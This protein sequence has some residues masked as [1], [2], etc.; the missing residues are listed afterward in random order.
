MSIND[1]RPILIMGATGY[2]GGRLIPRLLERGWRVRAAARNIAKLSGRPWT[3]HPRLEKVRAEMTDLNS[4]VQAALGCRAAYYLVHSMISAGKRY[5]EIDR[6]SALHMVAAVD[7]A[8][9][10]RLLYLGGLGEE[11]E[12]LSGHLRS[13]AEVGRILSSGRTPTTIL[14]A[15]MILGSGSASFEMLRYLAERLPI[16]VTP[17]WVHTQ[18]QP[19]AIRNVLDY[20]VGCL[21]N[22][23]TAGRRF[24]IGG[25]DIL[26]YAELFNIYASEAGLNRRWIVPT[27]FF[28]PKLSSYWIHMV[29]PV[30]ASIAR[31]LAEGL[32]NK[33]VVR[34][35]GIVNL[36]P[37]ELLTCREAMRSA[38]EKRRH[39]AMETCWLDSPAPPPEWPLCEDAEYTGGMTLKSSHRAVVQAAPG[40]AWLPIVRLGGQNGYYSSMFLW[41]LRGWLDRMVGGMGFGRKRRDPENLIEGDVFDFW[42]VVVVEPPRRLRLMAEVRSPGRAYLEFVL[43]PLPG[44]QTEIIQKSVYYPR[45][46]AGIVYWHALLQAHNWI[47]KGL[48]DGIVRQT[49]RPVLEGPTLIPPGQATK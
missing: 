17:R 44:G 39:D 43:T 16:M 29:T 10:E 35:R 32:R 31:P 26:T 33:V 21:E 30:P 25:P 14:R 8:G 2:V 23:N 48:L 49:G 20:L 13:R 7:A 3:N 19:I 41:R 12:D 40:L 6:L 18:V 27:P 11:S 46:V 34:D 28:S 1:D 37:A 15:A 22:P 45:G 9:L 24:D 38:L 4:L 42:R 36:V 5:R 47:F